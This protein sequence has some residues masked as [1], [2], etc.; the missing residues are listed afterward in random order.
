LQAQFLVPKHLD[1][2]R[3]KKQ[4]TVKLSRLT[5]FI[6]SWQGTEGNPIPVEDFVEVASIYGKNKIHLN[7]DPEMPDPVFTIY[8]TQKSI[9][10]KK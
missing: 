4:A 6:N 7:L 2:Y 10:N 8:G 1:S 5:S 9:P 3:A